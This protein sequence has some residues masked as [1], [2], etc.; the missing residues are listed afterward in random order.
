MGVANYDPAAIHIIFGVIPIE[1]YAD[2]TF[3]SVERNED[4]FALTVGADG[5][6]VRAKSNNKSGRI[7][8]TLLQSSI[9]NTLLSAA[10]VAD[11]LASDGVGPFIMTDG[12]GETLVS[13]QSCW[14]T[15]PAKTEFGKEAATRE[16]VLESDSINI[17][18]GGEDTL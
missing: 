13:A 11:E 9:T 4:M 6:G 1:G 14:I 7:T 17:L 5:E 2:G 16:W 8:L 15:K 3:V 12:N 10:M 18:N